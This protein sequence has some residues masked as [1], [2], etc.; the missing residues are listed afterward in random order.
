MV[1]T[2]HIS[3]LRDADKVITLLKSYHLKSV[4]L[5]INKVRGDLLMSGE[6]LSPKE[7]RELLRVSVLGIIP[8]EYDIYT[9]SLRVLHPAFKTLG[10]N[11]LLGK[12]KQ[13]DVTKK[14]RGFFGGI[15][16]FLKRSL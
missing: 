15:R 11:V 2:P 14:Y 6:S 5:I 13:Y 12:T 3:A 16:K 7:I 9:G 8:E 4:E 1:T 10:N